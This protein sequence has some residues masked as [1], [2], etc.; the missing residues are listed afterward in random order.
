MMKLADD[1]RSAM[2]GEV[3]RAAARGAALV[4]AI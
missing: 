3:D 2:H 1:W 4:P